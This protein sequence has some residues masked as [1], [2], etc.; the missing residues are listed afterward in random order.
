MTSVITARVPVEL[1]E[2]LDRRAAR[3][4]ISRSTLICRG[5]ELVTDGEA[6]RPRGLRCREVVGSVALNLGPATNSSVRQAL[7]QHASHS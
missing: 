5:V 2:K 7:R 4:G 6:G 1:V 3:E